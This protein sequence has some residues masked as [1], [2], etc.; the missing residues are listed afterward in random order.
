MKTTA[1]TVVVGMASILAADGGSRKRELKTAI[2]G[3]PVGLNFFLLNFVWDVAMHARHYEA[4]Y[5]LV[6]ALSP[7]H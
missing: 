7:M 2:E 5:S 3:R 6:Y 4:E 1:A